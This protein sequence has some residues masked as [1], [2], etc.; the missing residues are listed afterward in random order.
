MVSKGIVA[1]IDRHR[2]LNL[3]GAQVGKD[4]ENGK[5]YFGT[6]KLIPSDTTPLTSLNKHFKL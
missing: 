6:W 4:I 2:H 3:Q 1:G 5:E